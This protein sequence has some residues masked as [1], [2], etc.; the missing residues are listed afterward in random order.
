MA[1]VD[2]TVDILRSVVSTDRDAMSRTV[3]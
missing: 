3:Q 2:L 1:G